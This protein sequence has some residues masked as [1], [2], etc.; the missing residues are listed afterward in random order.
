MLIGLEVVVGHEWDFSFEV[1][2]NRVVEFRAHFLKYG[3]DFIVLFV[4]ILLA[5][6]LLSGYH[7]TILGEITEHGDGRLDLR[8]HGSPFI[9]YI[10]LS[11]TR[12]NFL[13]HLP[14][15]IYLVHQDLRNLLQSICAVCLPV[16]FRTR[17]PHCSR[18]FT[19]VTLKF[20][21]LE[22]LLFVV[23]GDKFFADELRTIDMVSDGEEF[24]DRPPF[25][26][27]FFGLFILEG[28]TELIEVWD[29]LDEIF[30]SVVLIVV[31]FADTGSFSKQS[32]PL[33][34]QFASQ[35]HWPPFC[36]LHLPE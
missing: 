3:V 36:T 18:V 24:L 7:I 13:F 5:K 9:I 19:Q 21:N 23:V 28:V 27:D 33:L 1:V 32:L 29:I 35:L 20:L 17:T 14:L 11:S 6:F 8:T 26:I 31:V 15:L 12:L 34:Y 2:E 22:P 30:A 25:A 4:I 16:I 10:K